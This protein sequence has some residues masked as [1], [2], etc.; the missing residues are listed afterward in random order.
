MTTTDPDAFAE[1]CTN[2]VGRVAANPSLAG[3]IVA[4]LATGKLAPSSG[5]MAINNIL[6]GSPGNHDLKEFL[7]TWNSFAPHMDAMD[8]A[9]ALKSALLSYELAES[10][11][12]F[13]TTVWTGPD[14]KGSEVRRTEAVVN[15]ILADAETDLLIVGYWLVTWTAQI[16][17][18]IDLLMQK[19]SKGVR[20]R[21]V[22]DPGDKPG[23]A[24]NF[25]ALDEHWPS[26]KDGMPREVYTWSEEMTKATSK[27]GKHYDRKLH[28]KVIVA[29][30]H[31]ALVTS[32]NL[33]GAGLL[34][35]L[36]MGLRIK[37]DTAKAVVRHFDLLISEG[38]LERRV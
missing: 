26:D 23:G 21:F 36:E 5:P 31:D 30:R 1:A 8:V 18:L 22:F 12:H 9:A 28:A 16:K 35:N 38:I 13:V 3:A 14:V 15:E 2:L 33:T 7:K 37:G 19:A 27:S 24:D 10:R 6:K 4:A 17:A 29:D 34:E 20:I 11:S 32:A 25:S